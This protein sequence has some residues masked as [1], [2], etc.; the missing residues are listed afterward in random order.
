MPLLIFMLI[1]IVEMWILIEVG[2]WIGAL[3]TI[4]LVVLTATIG[5]S[6]LKQQGLSTVMRARRIMDEG[7]I[8]ASELVSGVMIAVGGALLL[9]PGFVTDALGF[10]LL[11]PQTRQWLLFKLIDRYRDKIVVEGE[12][13][14]VDDRNF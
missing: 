1:P 14:R 7:A 10:A 3:P 4:A 13:H 5:L 9:T 6:L 12:F 11:I 8:P 2:G